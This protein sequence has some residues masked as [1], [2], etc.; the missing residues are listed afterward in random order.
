MYPQVSN[1]PAISKG[2]PD[3]IFGII[4]PLGEGAFGMVYKAVDQRDGELVA[5]K[6]MP[7]EVEMGNM[8]KE[9]KLLKSCK[10]PYIVNFR[11]AYIKEEMIWIAMEYCGAGSV[12]D[13]MKVTGKNLDEEQIQIVMK[14]SLKG[15]EYLHSKKLVHRD[16]KAGNVL[17]NHRGACKLADFGVAKDTALGDLAT[18]TI[19]SPYWMAPEVFGK[20]AHDTKVDIWSL[21]CTAIEMATGRPPYAQKALMELVFLIPD[22]KVPPPNLPETDMHWSED[23]RHFVSCCLVKDPKKRPNAKELG[24]HRWIQKAKGISVLHQ[25]VRKAMPLLDSYRQQQREMDEQQRQNGGTQTATMSQLMDTMQ[26]GHGAEDEFKGGT[27]V[28][29]YHTVNQPI[30][31]EEYDPSTMIGGYDDS[32][33][34]NNDDEEEDFQGATMLM[35]QDTVVTES[36]DED[37]GFDGGTV[38]IANGMEHDDRSQYAQYMKELKRKDAPSGPSSHSAVPQNSVAHKPHSVH[39]HHPLPPSNVHQPPHHSNPHTQYPPHSHPPQQQ[40]YPLHAQPQHGQHGQHGQMSYGQQSQTPRSMGSNYNVSSVSSQSNVHPHPPPHVRTRSKPKNR[41]FLPKKPVANGPM[42]NGGKPTA[43]NGSTS[44]GSMGSAARHS[45]FGQPPPHSNV[46]SQPYSQNQYPPQQRQ[47]PLAQSTSSGARAR[48][49][50]SF[51]IT[52]KRKVEQFKQKPLPSRSIANYSQKPLP[53]H[54]KPLPPM[55]T[56]NRTHSVPHHPQQ[57][58]PSAQSAYSQ[59]KV[60][61]HTVNTVKPQNPQKQQVAPSKASKPTPNGRPIGS[62]FKGTDLLKVDFAIPLNADRKTLQNLREKINNLYDADVTALEEFYDDQ[63]RRID[64][65]LQ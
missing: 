31:D 4:Q 34:S 65:Q 46:Q 48:G 49:S 20:G 15:L 47:Q 51:Q 64:E 55:S 2:D 40:H 43:R 45:P 54:S 18:T 8:E 6:I 59:R 41:I 21:G 23:F 19:G 10:S 30:N 13:L 26:I 25:W 62:L 27:A 60:P 37:D 29:P 57:S 36:E 39:P 32:N 11:G 1:Q 9:I 14:E 3:E 33:E 50:S 56:N 53:S 24:Q 35:A 52:P 61:V 22:P 5:V 63:L 58:I 28:S 42:T 12:L 38:N 17:L 16:I 44:V 7:Q